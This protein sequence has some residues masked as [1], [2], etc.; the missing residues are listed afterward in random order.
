MDQFHLA[1]R[2]LAQGLPLDIVAIKT[3]IEN[4]KPRDVQLVGRATNATLP[5]TLIAALCAVQGAAYQPHGLSV[6]V[7]LMAY[8]R[9]EPD[10]V[11][12]L[13]VEE[14]PPIKRRRSRE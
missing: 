10:M 7:L 3:E 11:D 5:D 2:A 12:A 13:A 4:L 14:K 9:G 1:C 6:A 8:L